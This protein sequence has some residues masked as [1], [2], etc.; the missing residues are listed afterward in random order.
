MIAADGS[1]APELSAAIF[2]SFQ[3]LIAPLK[4]P[5]MVSASS[6]RS[7]RPAT[8]YATAMGEM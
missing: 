2:G 4:M 5:A 6:F 7:V 8:L 3:V 1:V